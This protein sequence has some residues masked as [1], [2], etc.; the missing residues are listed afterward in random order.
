M[1]RNSATGYG[2]SYSLSGRQTRPRKAITGDAAVAGVAATGGD[3]GGAGGGIARPAN[4]KTG[5]DRRT[6]GASRRK[7]T[8]GVGLLWWR[9]TM[10]EPN[11]Y[12]DPTSILTSPAVSARSKTPTSSSAPGN[13]R[14]RAISNDPHP[15]HSGWRLG[16]SRGSVPAAAGRPST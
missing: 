14:S 11:D 16:T 8:P 10:P 13:T 9:A 6:K 12:R 15:M 4:S 5:T 3:A 1:T 7:G 2:G